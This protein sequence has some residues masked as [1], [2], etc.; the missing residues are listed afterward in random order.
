MSQKSTHN[1]KR[2]PPSENAEGGQ[3]DADWGFDSGEAD[4]AV[5]KKL[6]VA[7][8][9]CL[10]AGFGFVFYQ[11]FR[12]LRNDDAQHAGADVQTEQTEQVERIATGSTESESD[13]QQL[14]LRTGT[15]DPPAAPDASAT[16]IEVESP[17]YERDQPDSPLPDADEGWTLAQA[18]LAQSSPIDSKPT[19]LPPLPDRGDAHGFDPFAGQSEADTPET[20]AADMDAGLESRRPSEPPMLLWDEPAAPAAP[21]QSEPE[22]LP[23][24]TP[25]RPKT[26]RAGPQADPFA[27]DADSSDSPADPG[28]Q[29]PPGDD[30]Q[31][32]EEPQM[33]IFGDSSVPAEH[34]TEPPASTTIEAL[35][36]QSEP[37]PFGALDAD[38]TLADSADA[39]EFDP[40]AGPSPK[41]ESTNANSAD[42]SPARTG[43]SMETASEPGDD[44]ES[45]EDPFSFPQPA[46]PSPPAKGPPAGEP[47]LGPFPAAADSEPAASGAAPTWPQG[48]SS[49]RS[50]ES[51]ESP[52]AFPSADAT[53]TNAP[54]AAGSAPPRGMTFE[55]AVVESNGITSS[56]AETAPSTAP[57]NP[58]SFDAAPARPLV[59]SPHDAQ[60]V[61]GEREVTVT[62]SDSFWSI[63]EREYGHARY[64]TALARYNRDRVAKPEHLQSGM[65]IV[66]PPPE[67]LEDRFPELF[68]PAAQPGPTISPM[69][70]TS[71]SA[72]QAGLFLDEMQRPFYRVGE[73]DTLSTIAQQYLGRSSRWTEIYDLN[74]DRLQSPST[75]TIG[76][77]LK[78]PPD[79]SRV[80]VSPAG[81][82]DR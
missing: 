35:P 80:R 68:Q 33:L 31:P 47:A 38:E 41:D 11:K 69:S 46:S 45:V 73:K 6:A 39:S 24:I 28:T 4:P 26:P 57:L 77:E 81:G 75:L 52:A 14:A 82:F 43:P 48:S 49:S 36:V 42:A 27:F 65:K 70:G 67:V 58:F 76:M 62:P 79:A 50:R 54:E 17:F 15:P 23:Q 53:A 59:G 13:D 71:S 25:Q 22:A 34:A 12:L 40:F 32:L 21:P 60:R 55:P 56:G 16:S 78:L 5:E 19:Q 61:I 30:R 3:Q 44:F 20:S 74:K 64:F 7:L 37:Q 10:L 8:V 63:S 1:S 29:I 9:V 51:L 18:E 72:P 66:I 2:R